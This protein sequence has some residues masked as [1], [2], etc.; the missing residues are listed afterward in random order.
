MARLTTLIPSPLR[1]LARTVRNALRPIAPTTTD[2]LLEPEA[3]VYQIAA[4]PSQFLAEPGA[5]TRI[6]VTLH[7]PSSQPWSGTGRCPVSVRATW[8]TSRKQ[9][10]VHA[11]S[12]GPISLVPAGGQAT[13]SLP[14]KAP[15][16]LGHFLVQLDVMQNGE[17]FPPPNCRPLLL[18]AQVTGAAS[19][20]IDYHKVYATADLGRDFWTVVGPS[21]REEFERLSQV[22]LQHLIDL[23][24]T[25]DSHLLDVGCGTGQ[26][27]VAAEKFLSD[28]A[29]YFGTDLG[30]EAIAFCKKTYRRPNFRFAANEM[31]SLPNPGKKFDLVCLFSVFTHTYPDETVL[32]LAEIK[33]LLAPKGQIFADVFT[34]PLT[35]R[36]TGNRGAVELNREHFLRLVALTGMSAEVHMS[37][38]WKDY[39]KREFFV[40]R[41]V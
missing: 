10:I 38:D 9:P 2:H 6:S 40:F 13:F 5:T 17:E 7:N 39:G 23:G 24:L 14:V 33:K 35:D 4:S 22:K 41:P 26:V 34:S 19:G 12:E 20:D 27:T 15:T 30:E 8:L 29:S 18:D 11:P 32:L 16:N 36:Y 28:R 37:G 21:T 1:P 31:T 3:R 25:P